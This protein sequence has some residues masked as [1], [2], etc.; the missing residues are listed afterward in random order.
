MPS[1]P[2][3]CFF[4][5][6]PPRPLL[7]T[8]LLLTSY[9]HTRHSTAQRYSTVRRQRK[10]SQHTD[11]PTVWRG[12]YN[13]NAG[14]MCTCHVAK[15]HACMREVLRYALLRALEAVGGQTLACKQ[16]SKQPPA[17]QSDSQHTQQAPRGSQCSKGIRRGK[18][19]SFAGQLHRPTCTPRDSTRACSDKGSS[20]SSASAHRDC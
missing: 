2:S 19:L 15:K 20:S 8:L 16:A 9:I 6:Q 11:A 12:A 13:N 4:V 7:P 17:R 1:S 14:S 5:D 18:A 3:P 10:L